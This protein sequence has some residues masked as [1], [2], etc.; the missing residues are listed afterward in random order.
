M[1]T[2]IYWLHLLSKESGHTHTYTPNYRNILLYERNKYQCK[3]MSR[4]NENIFSYCVGGYKS[5]KELVLSMKRI[6]KKIQIAQNE[7]KEAD[8][9]DDNAKQTIFV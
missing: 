6:T 2:T 5:E 4:Q 8:G 1:L 9:E 7:L 3:N